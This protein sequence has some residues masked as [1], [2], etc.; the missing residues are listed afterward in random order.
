MAVK[1]Q[2]RH[3]D[4]LGVIEQALCNDPDTAYAFAALLSHIEDLI[5][6]GPEDIAHARSLL[7]TGIECAFSHTNDYKVALDRYR[8]YLRGDLAP[9][10]EA[11]PHAGRATSKGKSPIRRG[12]D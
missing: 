11:P 7:D 1:H 12:R 3:Q 4:L 5:E 2:T 6:S 8:R 9:Q 10:D